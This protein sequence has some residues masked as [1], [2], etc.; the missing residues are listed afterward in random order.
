MINVLVVEDSAVVLE[1]LVHILSA[2]PA[3]RIVGK[4][5]H[6]E[7]AIEMVERL[8]PDIVTMDIHMPRLDGI[9]ATRRIMETV[10]TPI[11]IVS[12]SSDPEEVAT[13]FAAIEAG[14]LAV[15]ERPYG[16]GH[17]EHERTAKGLVQT[18]KLMSE[19]RVVRRWARLRPGATAPAP[20]VAASVARR[21]EIVAIGA[22]TGGP[23]VLHCILEELPR[24]FS[25]PIVI[26]QHMAAG[27][28]DG[29]AEWLS[30]STGIPVRLAAHGDVVQAGRAY[31][32]PDAM[33]MRVEAGG[34]IVLADDPPE[35]GLRP[36][37]SYL[38]RSVAS[39]YRDRAV[40]GLLSGMG[41]DGARELKLLR[42]RGATTFAQDR[43]TS[44]VH[45]MP[46]EAIRLEGAAHVLPP[47]GIAAL[48]ARVGGK[49]R[50]EG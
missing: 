47:E 46:G 38:F 4:A 3:I 7:E 6:G 16:P 39:A 41:R 18:V 5:R 49:R 36:S 23:P 8:R 2:D 50:H 20:Q 1:L 27:F 10:P 11:V 35:N 28:L 12:G 19:V 9:E 40:A 29:F 31:L 13:T 44:V 24:E 26:V 48:L 32:A 17:P 30:H 42:D 21:V 43:E 25:L 14:A 45:G 37:V 33:Q 22:S 34:R 15:L